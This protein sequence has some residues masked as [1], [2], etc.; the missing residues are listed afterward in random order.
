M[1]VGLVVRHFDPQRGG[2]ESWTCQL[3]ERALTAGYD[4]HVVAQKFAVSER[5]LP[6]VRHRLPKIHSPYAFAAAIDDKLRELDLD[7][8]HDMGFGWRFDVLQPHFGAARAQFERK[9]L[10]MPPLARTV[11]RSLTAISPRWHQAERV[12]W[13]QYADH[14]RMVIALSKLVARDL[15]RT[16]GWPMERTRL[17]YNGVDLNR[18]KP[19]N[20]DMFR[21]EVRERLDIA[22]EEL[23]V[24]FVAHNFALK[25][26]PS[27]IKAVGSLRRSG[28]P[29]RLVALGGKASARYDRLAQQCGASECV[30]YLGA[31]KDTAPFYAAADVFVLPTWYDSCSLV[32]LEALATGIPV[33]TTRNNGASEILTSGRE[34]FVIDDPGDWQQLAQHID[35]LLEPELRERCGVAARRLAERYPL[36]ANYQQVMGLWQQIAGR[37]RLAA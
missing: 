11:R 4:V 28:R 33:V 10:S 19:Q 31:I 1:K 15:E 12:A 35:T 34:G 30:D 24:L 32:L 3:A 36:E 20:R 27:L 14:R 16:H 13:R 7:L 18:F 29:V 25:G 22:D 21:A 9:L 2:A 17:I 6:I 26:L 5:P 23:L 8:V 37:M